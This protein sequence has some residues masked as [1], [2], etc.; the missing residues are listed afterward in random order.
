MVQG[1]EDAAVQAVM[2]AKE[3]LKQTVVAAVA[4]RSVTLTQPVHRERARVEPDLRRRRKGLVAF[5]RRGAE[6]PVGSAALRPG[7]AQGPRAIVDAALVVAHRQRAP[8]EVDAALADGDDVVEPLVGLIHVMNFMTWIPAPSARCE[9]PWSVNST[10]APPPISITPRASGLANPAWIRGKF[11]HCAVPLSRP[12]KVARPCPY[13]C[14]SPAD[15]GS[16]SWSVSYCHST[17]QRCSSCM[18]HPK[19]SYLV[20]PTQVTA[21]A[22]SACPLPSAWGS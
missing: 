11:D 20:R 22:L 21:T 1:S 17:S 2:T 10:K 9:S 15:E 12:A 14:P 3:T 4:G 8:R 18:T 6:R 5:D 16:T 19:G 13:M 7:R